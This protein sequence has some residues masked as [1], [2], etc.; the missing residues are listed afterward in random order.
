MLGR[1]E[2]KKLE[3]DFLNNHFTKRERKMEMAARVLTLRFLIAVFGAL[4]LTGCENKEKIKALEEAAEARM[5][6][7][8]VQADLNRA[9]KQM[10]YLSEDLDTVTQSRDE[11]QEQIEKLTGERDKTIT[12]AQKEFEK[13]KDLTAKSNEQAESAGLLQNE[14]NQLK[15][16]IEEQRTAITEQ[17][18]MIE[19]L[20][21]IIELQQEIPEQQQEEK[22]EENIEPEQP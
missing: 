12:A 5:S 13:V 11:L 21:K 4:A 8:K 14:I 3:Q 2:S 9:K 22:E 15:A 7:A 19:E 1:Q 18:A 10:A 16:V 17:Q 6:L 20:Q